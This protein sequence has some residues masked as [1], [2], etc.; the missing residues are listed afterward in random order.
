LSRIKLLICDDHAVFREGLKGSLTDMEAEFVDAED[1]DEGLEVLGRDPDVDALLLD[2]SMPGSDPW[3]NLARLR[4]EHPSVPVIVVSGTEDP[5]T[6]RSAIDRG[7]SGFIPKSSAPRI[8]RRAIEL[9][10]EGGVYLP[11]QVLEGNPQTPVEREA[12]P[13]R[14]KRN[15]S[16]LTGRQ[17]EVAELLSRGL[18]N[19]EISSALK[20]AEGTVKAHISAIFDALDVTNRTEAVLAI[21]AE[22][23]D[24]DA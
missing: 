13:S 8:Y 18:T 17:A 23:A 9:V 14:R 12:K 19:S 4:S 24:D 15:S 6:V 11:P 1:F 5:K 10:L 3:S 7:A 16:R 22:I 2:L 21:Q 20:I